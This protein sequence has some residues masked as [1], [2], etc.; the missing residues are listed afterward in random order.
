MINIWQRKVA[1]LILLKAHPD[2]DSD[3]L[4]MTLA[5]RENENIPFNPIKNF[6]EIINP[7]AFAGYAQKIAAGAI[8]LPEYAARFIPAGGA[9]ASDLIRGQK[10]M[11]LENFG[12]NMQPKA[13][14]SFN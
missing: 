2:P 1:E 12:K 5:A 10:R 7:K 8:K 3:F 6:N 9:L 14:R 4:K 11:D 13:S